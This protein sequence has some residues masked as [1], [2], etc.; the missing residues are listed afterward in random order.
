MYGNMFGIIMKHKLKKKRNGKNKMKR[1]TQNRAAAEKH[2]NLCRGREISS[3]GWCSL[4]PGRSKPGLEMG[5]SSPD[6]AVPGAKPG[7]EPVMARDYRPVF[8]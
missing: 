5:A 8:Y 3:P 7:L 1:K 4:V 6:L 2:T